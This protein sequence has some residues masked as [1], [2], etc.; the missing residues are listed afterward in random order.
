MANPPHHPSISSMNQVV[1]GSLEELDRLFTGNEIKKG[2]SI[3]GLKECKETD[4][5]IDRDDFDDL[6]DLDDIPEITKQPIEKKEDKEFED[7]S[8][9]DDLDVEDDEFDD[10][11][12]ES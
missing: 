8:F 1:K 10:A 4:P 9:I 7:D 11:F 3:V 6:D 12:I 5:F 2:D